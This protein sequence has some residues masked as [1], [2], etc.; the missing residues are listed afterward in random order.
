[1]TIVKTPVKG[2]RSSEKWFQLSNQTVIGGGR[3]EITS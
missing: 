1:M 2:D 3:V